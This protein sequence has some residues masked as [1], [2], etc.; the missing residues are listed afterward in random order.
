LKAFGKFKYD[1]FKWNLC[2]DLK[3]V[4]LFLGMQNGYTKY[5]YLLCDW[6]NRNKKNH[7]VNQ[8]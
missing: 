1:E 7:Y 8:L 2:C 5:C 4:T 3:V 6:D